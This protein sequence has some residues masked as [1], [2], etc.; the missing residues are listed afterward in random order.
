VDTAF[1]LSHK[2]Q[3]L[4]RTQNMKAQQ[5]RLETCFL[6]FPGWSPLRYPVYR[7]FV[8]S[9]CSP[10]TVEAQVSHPLRTA[11]LAVQLSLGTSVLV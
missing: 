11:R 9:G 8:A 1:P 7:G 2:K 3:P 10:F 6:F 5:A 4:G